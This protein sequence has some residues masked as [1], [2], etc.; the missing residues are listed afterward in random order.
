MDTAMFWMVTGLL[1]AVH[2]MAGHRWGVRGAGVAVVVAIATPWLL[3]LVQVI[4]HAVQPDAGWTE[5]LGM[6]VLFSGFASLG[7]GLLALTC[8]A[9]GVMGRGTGPFRLG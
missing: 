7:W 1:A 9:I 6:T 4:G 5:W 8:G 3:P 2:M